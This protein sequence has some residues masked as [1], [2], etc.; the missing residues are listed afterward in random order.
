MLNSSDSFA[1]DILQGLSQN[2]RRLSSTYFYDDL[3]SALFSEIMNLPE[4]YLSRSEYEIL[5]QQTDAIFQWLP[6][7]QRLEL[8]ELGAG[9]GTKTLALLNY[10]MQ[11]GIDFRYIPIDIS[12]AALEKLSNYIH[13]QLPAAPVFPQTGN[14][15]ELLGKQKSSDQPRLIL[16]LGSNIGNF[17]HQQAISFIRQIKDTMQSHDR[18][19]V[20]FDLVKHPKMIREAY[21]DSSGLTKAFNLN[22]LKRINQ[23]FN[24]DFDLLQFDHYESYDPELSEAR[25]YLI[26]LKPQIVTLRDLQFSVK[27]ETWDYIHVEVSRKYKPSTLQQLAAQSGFEIETA[28]YDCKHYFTDQVWKP[29]A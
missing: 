20:G 19:L 22:L 26:S 18:L 3:G 8:M 12:S 4:Y 29:I 27:F 28:L 10:L 21:N 15:F 23:E 25:S 5:S 2:P 16:F 24:G 14:Y 7:G 9:D 17:S 1:Q 11:K 13:E 6:S